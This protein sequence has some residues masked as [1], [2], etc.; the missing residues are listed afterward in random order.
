MAT[1]DLTTYTEV[2]PNS[3]L[4]VISNKITCINLYR[5]DGAYIYKNKGLNFFDADFIHNFEI[6]IDGTT[7]FNSHAFP[8]MMSNDLDVFIN[9]K[10]A[11]KSFICVYLFQF[12]DFSQ[13][14]IVEEHAGGEYTQNYN[15]SYDENYYLQIERDESVGTY[16]T[17]YLRIYSDSS[18]ITLLTTLTLN[19]HSKIDFKYIF[20]MNSMDDSGSE[21]SAFNG[22][23]QN[24]DL[25]LAIIPDVPGLEYTLSDNKLHFSFT[26]NRL[27]YTLTEED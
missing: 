25:N 18:R 24:Y 4:T 2:D 10:D 22:Y 6:F 13:I 7:V 26:Y 1:E 3:K 8:W 20:A 16:G 12:N 5:P 19:L 27:H 14:Y 23:V 17:L 9:L 11:S 21:T 15:L